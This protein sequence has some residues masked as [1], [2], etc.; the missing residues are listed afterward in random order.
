M[1]QGL[2]VDNFVGCT[3]MCT[4]RGHKKFSRPLF[5]RTSYGL[6]KILCAALFVLN[7]MEML[8]IDKG[9]HI[10]GICYVCL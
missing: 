3:C 5:N 4:T 9:L 6:L 7:C 1:V 8:D 10:L 2:V